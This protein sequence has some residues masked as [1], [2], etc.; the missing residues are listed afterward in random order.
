MKTRRLEIFFDPGAGFLLGP[1]E[2]H[3]VATT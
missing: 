2:M 3:S 1:F